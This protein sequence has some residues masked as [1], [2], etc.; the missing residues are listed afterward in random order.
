M[1]VISKA[2]TKILQKIMTFQKLAKTQFGQYLFIFQNNT[3]K[4][5]E[6]HITMVMT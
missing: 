2:C 1:T 3:L 4:F 5:Q 6:K